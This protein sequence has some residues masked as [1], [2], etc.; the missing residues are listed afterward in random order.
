[1]K[2][3]PLAA[4]HAAPVSKTGMINAK[5]TIRLSKDFSPSF[6]VPGGTGRRLALFALLAFMLSGC[7]TPK[8]EGAVGYIHGFAGMAAADDPEAVM[9]ARDVLSAGGNAVDAATALY[10]SLAA[11]LP[12]TATLGGGGT[13]VVHD[14]AKRLTRVIEFPA[15]AASPGS[16]PV[17][18]PAN[19]RGFFAMQ[20]TYGKF[21]WASLLAPA[22]RMARNGVMVSRGLAGELAAAAP[23]LA[24]DPAAR[25]IFFHADGQVLAEGDRMRNYDLAA[26]I[27]RLRR[28]PGALY[29]GD[30]QREVAAAAQSIGAG[31]TARDLADLRPRFVEPAE[32][33]LGDDTVVAPPGAGLVALVKAGAGGTLPAAADG[34]RTPVGTGFVVL[35]GKG[36]AVACAVS[37][38]GVFGSFQVA[39]GTGMVLAAPPRPGVAAVPAM[40]VNKPT[41]EVHFAGAASGGDP[42][43]ALATTLIDTVIHRQGIDQAVSAGSAGAARVNAL[44]CRGGRPDARRCRVS[45]DPRGYGYAVS[46]GADQ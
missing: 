44:A 35:D 32:A 8:P 41:G 23:R 3:I 39:P 18:V 17:A 26:V 34:G 12:S 27:A 1:M 37:A 38:N 16:V 19:V 43:A 24:A 15:V 9:V 36:D 6:A 7:A 31:L 33:G 45:T 11:T 20:A 21:R 14:K 13:C 42:D 28:N 22:Q 40:V 2:D 4:A 46:V 29:S 25:K 30:L 5:R 10:F